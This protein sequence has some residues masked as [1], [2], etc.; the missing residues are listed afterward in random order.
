[1]SGGGSFAVFLWNSTVQASNCTVTSANGGNGGNGGG[2][3]VG[4]TGGPGGPQNGYGGGGEQ[5]D[6]S[7]GGR[8]GAGGDGGAGGAGGGGPTVGVVRGG[9]AVWSA[10]ATTITTGNPGF[11]GTSAAGSGA[12]GLEVAVY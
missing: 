4:G 6:G 5:D 8:G 1:M 12:V 11:G 9:G 7:N 10:T 2:G 3:G